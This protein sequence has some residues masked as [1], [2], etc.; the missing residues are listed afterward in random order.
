MLI[1]KRFKD[2]SGSPTSSM[3]EMVQQVTKGSQEILHRI[4]LINQEIASLQEIATAATKRKSRKRRYIKTNKVLIVSKV[5]N[6]IAA[7]EGSSRGSGEKPT[8]R[9]SAVRRCGRCSEIGHNSCT[10][11]VEI[12]DAEDSN[13]FEE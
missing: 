1:K 10:Y 3:N 7:K 9:V 13:E 2:N 12:E 8:K 11:K 6:L 5:T 4:V